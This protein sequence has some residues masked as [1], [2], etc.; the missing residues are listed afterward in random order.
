MLLALAGLCTRFVFALIHFSYFRELSFWQILESLFFGFR[1]DL[2]VSAILCVPFIFL[3][4]LIYR[5]RLGLKMSFFYLLPL[6]ILIGFQASDSMYFSESHKHLGNEIRT[7]WVSW[8]P[9]IET[10]LVDHFG[11]TFCVFI[12]IGF[13]SFVV[14]K[15]TKIH[16]RK[17]YGLGLEASLFVIL[18]LNFVFI[19]GGL[20]EHRMR[21][22]NVYNWVREPKQVVLTLNGSY[23]MLLSLW[24]NNKVGLFPVFSLPREKVQRGLEE[25]GYFKRNPLERVLKKDLGKKYN[26]FLIILES[27]STHFMYKGER[28]FVPF[29]DSLKEKSLRPLDTLASGRRSPE[30][31]LAI[32]C[33]TPNPLGAM[34][35]YTQLENHDFSCIPEMLRN[36][37]YDTL[38]LQGTFR[39]TV[40][41]GS[42]SRKL[43]FD[44]D[45]GRENFSKT[46]Y[47]LGFWG[48]HD[49]DLYAFGLD[50]IK[51]QEL[52]EPF[53]LTF[54]TTTTHGWSFPEE[55][56]PLL[57][58]KDPDSQKRN[59][60]HF[61]DQSLKDFMESPVL[62]ELKN[63]SLFVVIAD[64]TI[65]VEGGIWEHFSIPFLIYVPDQPQAMGLVET[66]ASQRDMAPTLLDFLGMKIP[67]EFTGRSLL[68]PSQRGVDYYQDGILGWI[69]GDHRVEVQ[70]N[71]GSVKSCYQ[72]SQRN[73]EKR[74]CQDF[75]QDLA[76]QGVGFTE[77]TQK[78][79]FSNRVKDFGRDILKVQ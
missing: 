43:G 69:V 17:S 34:I 53:L 71:N 15:K 4:T 39:E 67:T 47:K 56:T 32:S 77:Y 30:G 7:F 55:A 70:L 60:I 75:H 72:R 35:V 50:K 40:N 10:A 19:R 20:Q 45:Y 76:H 28:S 16:D 18:V 6:F 49:P 29:Y 62:G 54:F 46:K 48:V 12:F 44:K 25:G 22:I 66:S 27:W 9:L 38:F 73:W 58:A 5:L 11:L 1:F 23:S 51:N 64:H 59:L 61:A 74:V 33:S 14:L 21:P 8:K 41:M 36:R 79:L 52:K 26:V 65:D 3:A 42:L 68:R 57:K 63:P 37:G 24:Y 13:L 2:S 78:L 31:F